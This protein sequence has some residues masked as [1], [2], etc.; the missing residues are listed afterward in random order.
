MTKNPYD[1][2]RLE[3]PPVCWACGRSDR[4]RPSWWN[5]P[6]LIERSHIVNKP[7][8]EDRRAVV[9]LCS[10]CH[11]IQHGETFY[12]L[13]DAPVVPLTVANML[14]LKR[15]HDPAFYD[16]QWLEAHTVGKLPRAKRP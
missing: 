2:I 10:L 14:W 4:D 11:R 7:R 16:R 13:R 15:Q 9:L 6:W 12:N 8:A 5:A 3:F 1:T